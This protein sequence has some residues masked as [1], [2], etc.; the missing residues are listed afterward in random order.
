VAGRQISDAFMI[1]NEVVT[2]MVHNKRS[3]IL[4][5]LD[6]EKAFDNVCWNLWII[7][8]IDTVLGK[9]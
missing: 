4:C 6:M 9:N 5:K 3:K 8:C 7:C 1:A 2:E